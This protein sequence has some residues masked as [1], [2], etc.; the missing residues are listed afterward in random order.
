VSIPA[1]R[2]LGS[3]SSRILV[4]DDEEDVRT[5]LARFLETEGYQVEVAA[6]LRN[7]NP[8]DLPNFSA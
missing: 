2:P 4:V 3:I 8:A 7:L 1:A 5:L 6:D